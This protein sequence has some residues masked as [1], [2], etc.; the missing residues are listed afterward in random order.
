[1]KFRRRL[2]FEAGQ[3]L[4]E[5]VQTSLKTNHLLLQAQ[6]RLRLSQ[7]S[8]VRLRGLDKTNQPLRL[9]T[10]RTPLLSATSPRRPTDTGGARTSGARAR[11]RAGATQSLATTGRVVTRL[12][13]CQTF[14]KTS[15]TRKSSMQTSMSRKSSS[16]SR[17]GRREWGSSHEDEELQQAGSVAVPMW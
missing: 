4:F 11:G 10:V 6:L 9:A 3:T 8:V 14:S 16:C 15:Q 1:M 5:G 17:H 13:V 12:R 2:G 7:G